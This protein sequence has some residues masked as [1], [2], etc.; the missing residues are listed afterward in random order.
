MAAKFS[1]SHPKDGGSVNVSLKQPFFIAYGQC[2][3]KKIVTFTGALV[4]PKVAVVGN[5]LRKPRMD[6]HPVT[7]PYWALRFDLPKDIASG[8]YWL[9]V[10]AVD[11]DGNLD[12]QRGKIKLVVS[13][14]D[15]IV[16]QCPNPSGQT[17]CPHFWA[18]GTTGEGNPVKVAVDTTPP[19]VVDAVVGRNSWSAELTLPV[20]SGM[21]LEVSDADDT[22][23]VKA[24][25][26]KTDNSAC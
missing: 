7:Y 24:T 25:G 9:T 5:L 1:V 16:I 8:D 22:N 13:T 19:T 4:G 10:S 3:D 2:A 21:T 14:R 12:T 18:Y 15:N 6:S 20:G 17:V 26:L 11:S 23:P